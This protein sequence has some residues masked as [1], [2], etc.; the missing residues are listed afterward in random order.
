MLHFIDHPID[1]SNVAKATENMSWSN[2]AMAIANQ[3]V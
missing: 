2:F 1:R 3:R